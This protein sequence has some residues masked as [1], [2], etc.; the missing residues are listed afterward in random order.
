MG[1]E[2]PQ[3]RCE[4]IDHIIEADV[5]NNRILSAGKGRLIG[6]YHL[7]LLYMILAGSLQDRLASNWKWSKC[8]QYTLRVQGL[9]HLDHRDQ[10]GSVRKTHSR[11]S[12]FEQDYRPRQAR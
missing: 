9:L 1:L 2:V 12:T 6:F 10:L 3:A 8:L 11:L 7:S 4:G 5:A